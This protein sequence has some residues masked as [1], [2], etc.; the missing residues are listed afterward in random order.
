[1]QRVRDYIG[2]PVICVNSGNQIGTVQDVM[3]DTYWNIEGI[4]IDAKHWFSSIRYVEWEDIVSFGED[5]VTV[6]DLE[7]VKELENSDSV[8]FLECGKM[9]IKGSPLMTVNG[10]QLGRVEDVYFNQKMGKPLIGFEVSEGFISDIKDGRK[11][12]PVPN[13]AVKG[14]DAIIVPV[15]CKDELQ[16]YAVTIVE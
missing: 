7:K 9:P 1:M 11:W 16:E 15:H 3:I 8:Y 2:L 6:T 12:L 10:E 5:A 13:E 14:D 4:M